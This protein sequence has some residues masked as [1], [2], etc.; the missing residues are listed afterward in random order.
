MAFYSLYQT[1]KCLHG[2]VC[3]VFHPSAFHQGETT[4]HAETDHCNLQFIYYLYG[5]I[6]SKLVF[7]SGV[8]HMKQQERHES[9]GLC[10]CVL[11]K[12]LLLMSFC[13]I[14]EFSL[15]FAAEIIKTLILWLLQEKQGISDTSH[16]SP[17][18]HISLCYMQ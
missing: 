1:I 8:F 14:R 15:V 6:T 16:S 5:H 2:T 3:K 7:Q 10:K 11:G 12:L 9:R 4:C 13:H 17:Y 18:T